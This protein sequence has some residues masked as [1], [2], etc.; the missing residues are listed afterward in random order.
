MVL[1]K[2]LSALLTLYWKVLMTSLCVCAGLSAYLVV[3]YVIDCIFVYFRL[4]SRIICYAGTL[5]SI[6]LSFLAS[7]WVPATLFLIF[8]PYTAAGGLLSAQVVFSV[9]AL[10]EHLRRLSGDNFVYAMYYGLEAGV[11][12]TRIQVIDSS[13]FNNCDCCILKC[14][15]PFQ[16]LL[17]LDEVHSSSKL[18]VVVSGTSLQCVLVC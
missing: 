11:A 18:A 13:E 6:T 4:E 12:V 14:T 10:L 2:F 3:C 1:I 15:L 5:E 17:N 8:V 16:N 9:L 7:A